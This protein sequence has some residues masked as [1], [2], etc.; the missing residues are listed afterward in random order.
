MRE[1][2]ATGLVDA[3]ALEQLGGMPRPAILAARRTEAQ[4]MGVKL[5]RAG[6]RS[7]DQ[8]A[9]AS[10]STRS[11]WWPSR[12]VP[13]VSWAAR[14]T[15]TWKLDNSRTNVGA[16]AWVGATWSRRAASSTWSVL[17]SSFFGT[18]QPPPSATVAFWPAVIVTGQRRAWRLAPRKRSMTR[19]PTPV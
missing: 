2:C 16:S 8:T 6:Q 12:H 14:V 10:A 13:K 19:R 1:C 3:E 11:S 5:V 7:A 4:H 15:F 17:T 9:R 18:R